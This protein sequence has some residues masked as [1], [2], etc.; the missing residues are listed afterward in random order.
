MN[1]PQTVGHY[2]L[3]HS[4]AVLIGKDVPGTVRLD[5]REAIQTLTIPTSPAQDTVMQQV[6]SKA[7]GQ[8]RPY[9]LVS[10]NCSIFVE[11]VLRAGGLQVPNTIFPR[12]LFRQLQETYGEPRAV[13]DLFLIGP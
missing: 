6:L 4:I 11:E 12:Q 13:P 2:P 8:A 1:T 10:R 7:L 3:E 9:N 5:P